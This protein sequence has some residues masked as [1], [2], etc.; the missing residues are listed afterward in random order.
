[1]TLIEPQEV[2]DGMTQAGEACRGIGRAL[3]GGVFA[4]RDLER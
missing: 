2:G 4:G 3:D 1:M